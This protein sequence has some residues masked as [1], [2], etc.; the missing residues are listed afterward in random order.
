MSLRDDIKKLATEHPET[1]RH[2][3]ALLKPK[4]ADARVLRQV[5]EHF[6]R[7]H[8]FKYE[9]GENVWG[10]PNAAVSVW[11]DNDEPVYAASLSV[12]WADDAF[13]IS[14]HQGRK[15]G[16]YETGATSAPAIIREAEAFA[17]KNSD[18]L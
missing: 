7:K 9:I 6:A 10:D 15:S 1:R 18:L 13:H 11:D 16:G 12:E 2:L 4:K 3:V 8:G 5:G 17:R 14:I